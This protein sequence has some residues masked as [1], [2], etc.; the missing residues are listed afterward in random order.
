MGFNFNLAPFPFRT[1]LVDKN[2][3]IDNQIW[4]RALNALQQSVNQNTAPGT[5][6]KLP[7]KPVEGMIFGVTDS[8]VNAWGSVIAGG[9]THHVLGYYNGTNWTVI[10]T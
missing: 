2:R 10:G 9:G 8:T 4:L 7:A 5:F 3:M 1:P 6:A